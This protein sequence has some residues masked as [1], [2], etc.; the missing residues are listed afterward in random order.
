MRFLTDFFAFP[1]D[2]VGEDDKEER[3]HRELHA[4]RP[5]AQTFG[6]DDM[7]ENRYNHGTDRNADNP[8]GVVQRRRH[9]G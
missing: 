3:R 6:I 1:A 5:G 4:V 8:V 7:A 9:R 2:L